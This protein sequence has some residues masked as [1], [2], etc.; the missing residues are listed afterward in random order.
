MVEAIAYGGPS[1]APDRVLWGTDFPHPNISGPMPDD[2]R[3]LAL[4]ADIAR[5]P[6]E[7]SK[8]LVDN[9]AEFFGFG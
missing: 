4:L 5:E 3:L 6:D 1:P 8:L 7:L 2:G 9:P